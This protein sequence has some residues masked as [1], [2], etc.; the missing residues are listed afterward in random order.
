MNE[1]A[2][3]VVRH[4]L[5]TVGGSLVAKGLITATLWDQVTGAVIVLAGVAWS[6]ISK[7]VAK[8][9]GLPVSDTTPE[10]K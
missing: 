3:S 2:S 4:T 7:A 1:I 5:T 6:L 10:S 8:K 9:T